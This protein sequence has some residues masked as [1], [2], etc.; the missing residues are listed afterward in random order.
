MK[1]AVYILCGVALA[2]LLLVGGCAG[3][4]FYKKNQEENVMTELLNEKPT[5]LKYLGLIEE[6]NVDLGDTDKRSPNGELMIL[7]VKGSENS[8]TLT[9]G[10]I[11]EGNQTVSLMELKLS[12]GT[13]IDLNGQ[14]E[15]LGWGT[16][17]TATSSDPIEKL[18]AD[19]IVEKAIRKSLKKL[20]G[21]LTKT[22]LV[23]VTI[24]NMDNSQITDEGLKELAK[25]QQLEELYMYRTQITDAG[26]KELARLQKLESLSVIGTK[27]TKAGVAELKKALPNCLISGGL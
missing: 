25:L 18:I 5:L 2:G 10:N 21:E 16:E 6:V 9:Y 14:L 7:S 26:L 17:T 13:V 12:D 15:I 20:T 22:D 24:L 27:V 11:T 19:P 23:K 3:L 4:F 1:K 8:G